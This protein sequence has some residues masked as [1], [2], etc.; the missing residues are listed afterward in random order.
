[1]TIDV[2]K[3]KKP[4]NYN[5]AMTYLENRVTDIH[6]NKSNE[7]IWILEHP[8]IFTAGKSYKSSDIIDKSI[9]L[10]CLGNI[11]IIFCQVYLKGSYSNSSRTQKWKT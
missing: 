9:N 5:K 7:L 6:N 2:K 1:M 4:V 8:P 3:S 11:L 10:V